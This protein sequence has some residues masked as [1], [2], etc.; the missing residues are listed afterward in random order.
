MNGNFD[1]SQTLNADGSVTVRGWISWQT[2][3]DP[4][5][6]NIS[7]EIK[8]TSGPGSPRAM[9]QPV[10]ITRGQSKMGDK[11]PWQVT[12]TPTNGGSLRA[13]AADAKAWVKTLAGANYYDWQ[14]SPNLS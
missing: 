10:Q 7:A 14:A 6:C 9:S 11:V 8:Q 5:P 1:A 2:A 3:Q 4:D 13:G 12:A